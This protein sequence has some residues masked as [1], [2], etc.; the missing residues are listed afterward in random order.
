TSDA[1]GVSVAMNAAGDRMAIG[2]SGDDGA[3]NVVLNMGAVYLFSF[4]DSSFSS[5][6]LKGIIGKGYTGSGNIDVGLSGADAFGTSVA[7][8]A[9]GDSLAVGAVGDDGFGES[10]SA[11]GAVYLFTFADSNFSGGTH[12]GTIGKDYAGAGDFNLAPLE[13]DDSFGRSVSLNAAGNRLAVGT[14]TDNG[15][16]N[17]AAD[18]GAVYLLSFAD[19][20]FGG[21]SHAGTIGNGYIGAGDVSLSGVAA[22][23]LL[24]VSVALNAAGDRLAIGAAGDDGAGNAAD[25]SGAIHLISFTDT[26]FSGGT[27]SGT[28]G[29]GYVGGGDTNIS[30]LGAGDSFGYSVALNAAGNR[31]AAGAL[32]DAGSGDTTAG[33]GAVYLLSFSDG[34][35]SSGAQTAIVGKGYTGGKNIGI[36]EIEGSD[37]FGFSVALNGAGD[38]LAIGTYGDDGGNNASTGAG[39][40]Y[41]LGFSD[42][43]FSNGAVRGVLSRDSWH[44]GDIDI[45][46]LDSGDSFGVSVALN[47]AGDRMAVG[48]WA[49]SGFGNVTSGSGAVYLFSFDDANF[50]GG[51]L[52][53]IIGKGYAGGKNVDMPG[54]EMNDWFGSGVALNDSGDRL[55]VG[56]LG[57]DGGSTTNTGAVYLFTFSDDDFSDGTHVATVGKGYG[58]DVS[59]LA[60]NDQFGIS[61]ALNAAG[62]R[63]AVGAIGDKGANDDLTSA[64]AAYLI[65]FNDSNFTGGAVA[66]VIGADYAGTNDI[67]VTQ[68][69]A[70]DQFGVSVALNGAGNRLAVGAIGDGGSGDVAS[71]S[72]AVHLFSFTDDDFTGG[73]HTGTI[74]KGYTGGANVNVGALEAADQFG[75]G[76]SL[77]DA[78]NRLAVGAFGDGG[79]ANSAAGSG[80]VYLL[81]FTDGNFSG[82]SVT[83]TLG[84]NY[85]GSDKINVISLDNS[86]QF[87]VSVALNGAGDRLA[88]GATG[89]GGASNRTAVSGAVYLFRFE[90]TNFYGGSLVGMVGDGY[91][92]KRDIALNAA[93]DTGEQFGMAVALNGAGDRLAVG[94]Y[95]D[96]GAGNAAAASGAVYLFSFSDDQYS[97]GAL[98]AIVG[99]GYVGGKNVN[100]AQLDAADG[101]GFS[102]SL[103]DDGDRMAVGAWADAGLGNTTGGAGAVYLF[104]FSDDSFAGGAHVGTIGKGYTGTGNID[105]T[106]LAAADRFGTSVAL[107][108]AGDRLAAGAYLDD[109]VSGGA[110]D[111][112]GAVYLFR[113][114]DTDFGGGTHS[115]TIGKG[116]VGVGDVNVASLDTGDYF[117]VSAALNSVGD[118]LAVGATGDNGSGNSTTDAGAV[119]L[120]TFTNGD[121][122]GGALAG[123]IGKG[124]SGGKSRD[125]AALEASD[126]FGRSVA[127][128]GDGDY[129]VA[130]A[131]YDDG[132][133]NAVENAGALYLFTFSDTSFTG[134]VHKGTIGSGYAGTF[135]TALA[136]GT[137]DNLGV[138]AALSANGFRLAAGANGDDGASN[139]I[140]NSGAV[141]LFTTDLAAAGGLSYADDPDATVNISATSLAALLAAGTNLTL[142]ASNDITVSAAVT[143]NNALGDGGD[144]TLQAGRSVLLNASITTDNGDLTLIANDTLAN[145]VVDAHRDSGAAAITMGV[146][147]AIAAGTG[148]VTI[149]LRN[150]AGKTNT[151]AGDITLRAITAGA[152]TV[153][154]AATAGDILLNGNITTSGAQAYT[155]ERDI[156]LAASTTLTVTGAATLGMDAARQVSLTTGAKIENTYAGGLTP[157][158][159]IDI[160]ANRRATADAGT[161]SGIDLSGA[162]IRTAAGAAGSIALSARG[163]ASD[164]RGINMLGG[165]TIEAL[166]SGTI[167]LHGT[168]GTG[169]GGTTYGVF[170]HQ[171]SQVI[172]TNGDIEITGEAVGSGVAPGLY[173]FSGSQVR[174]TGTGDIALIGSAVAGGQGVWIASS[175]AGVHT[176]SGDISITATSGDGGQPDFTIGSGGTLGSANTNDITINAD[177]I[178][179]TGTVSG[180]GILTIQSRTDGRTIGL[181]S[182]A[183]DLAIDAAS[184]ANIQ[185]GFSEI[186]IGN[187]DAGAIT[188]GSGLSA[189][190]DNLRLQSAGALAIDGTLSTGSNRLTL[191]V[192]GGGTQ[193]AALTA[194]QLLLL[195][196]ASNYTFNH[197]GNTI[198]TLAASVGSGSISLTNG[199]GTSFSVGAIG[200]TEG[201]AAASIALVSSPTNG[202]ITFTRGV[203]TTGAQSY[204]SARDIKVSTGNVTLSASGE[205]PITLTAARQIVLSGTS[206]IENTNTTATGKFD[207]IILNANLADSAAEAN[208]HGIYG[209]NTKIMASG[210]GNIKLAGRG[211]ASSNNAQTARAGITFSGSTIQSE[212]GD[213]S[214]TGHGGGGTADRAMSGVVLQ[215]GSKFATV[216]GGNIDIKAYGSDAEGAS[217]AAAF[218][219][220]TGIV[221]A[222][223]SGSLTILGDGGDGNGLHGVRLNTVSRFQTAS[224]AISITGLGGNG[225]TAAH[226]VNIT[227]GTVSSGG[228]LTIDGTGGDETGHGIAIQGPV[229]ALG[230]ASISMTGHASGTSSNNS[231]ILVT[232]GGSITSA[233]GDITLTATADGTAGNFPALYVLGGATT[234]IQ[235]TAGGDIT[236]QGTRRNGIGE[237]VWIGSGGGRVQ[238][239][240]GDISITGVTENSTGSN[241][242]DGARIAASGQV[243]TSAGGDI[244]LTGTAAGSG[245]DVGL[246]GTGVLG[247]TATGD[248]TITGDTIGIAVTSSVA[249]SG[250]LTIQTR[251]AGRTIGIGTGAGGDLTLSA[252]AL[253]RLQNGF[254]E[255][256]IG[257]S[258]AGAISVGTGLSA[259]TDNLRLVGS[260]TLAVDGVL[261]TGGNRLT[262][263]IAG[264]TTQ[265]AGITATQLLLLND[266]GAYT[267]TNT[268]N[269][270]GTLAADTDVIELTHGGAGALAIG[271]V[272]A[273]SGIT[274]TSVSLTATQATSSLN[275]NQD[276]TTSGAQTY[277]ATLGNITVNSGADLLV[278]GKATLALTAGARILLSGGTL[279]NSYTADSDAFEAITLKA[280]EAGTGTGSGDAAIKLAGGAGISTAA[281]GGGNISLLGKGGAS[282]SHGIFVD[283]STIESLGAGTLTLTGTGGT[284]AGGTNIGIYLKGTDTDVVSNSGAMLISG[285]G[286]ASTGPQNYGVHIHDGATIASTGTGDD[287]AAIEIIGAAGGTGSGATNI[288]VYVADTSAAITSIDGDISVTGTG[289]A[290]STSNNNIGV[291]LINDA[292]IESTGTTANAAKITVIGNAGGT[293]ALSANNQGVSLQGAA[294]TITSA[295]GDIAITGTGSETAGSANNHGIHILEGAHIASTGTTPGAAKITL[296]GQGGGDAASATTN[297]NIGIY[298]SS[299]NTYI[300]S[301]VGDITMT[302]TGGAG[303]DG[304]DAHHYGIQLG[305]GTQVRSTGSDANAADIIVSGTGGSGTG[306]KRNG[307]YLNAVEALKSDAG[308]ISITARGGVSAGGTGNDGLYVSGVGTKVQ[309]GSGTIVVD[310]AKGGGTGKDLNNLTG[311][312]AVQSTT[313]RWI[314]YLTHPDNSTL[315]NLASGNLPIWGKTQLTLAPGSVGSGNRYVFANQPTLTVSTS[316]SDSKTYGTEYTFPT[317]TR[318]INYSVSGIV[319]ASSYQSVWTQETLSDLGISGAPEFSS[320]GAA[321]AANVAGSPYAINIA[322]G[323][324]ASSA[325]YAFGTPSSTGS[326]TVTPKTLT[327]TGVTAA[328]K[329]YDGDDDADLSGGAL[330]GVVGSD[331]VEFSAGAGAFASKNVGTWVVTATGYTLSGSAAANYEL[332]QPTVANATI[333]AKVLTLTGVAAAGKD[334][335]GNADAD[336]SGGSLVGIVGSEDVEFSAGSGTFASKNVGTWTITTTGYMLSGGDAGNYTLTQPAVANAT[337]SAKAL[338][339]TG[340]TAAGTDYD[341]DADADLSGGSLV[342]IVGSEDVE[343]AEGSG[344]FSSRNVGT[345]SVTASG[346]TLTGDDAGNYTLTQPTVATAT[347][348]AKA[349][350]LSSVT[351]AG[352]DYDGDNTADLS[353]GALVGI[354][355]SED[356]SFSA[357]SGTFASKNVGTWTITTT[358]YTLTG[359]DAGNYTLTQP[360]VANAT[361]SAK[362]L[363][364]TGVGAAGKDYDGNDA[365]ALSG[366]TLI[367][368]VG[369]E[370]VTF[371]AGSGN[372]SSKN[373]GTWSITTSGY[374]LS[375]DDAGNYTLTQPTVASAAI[376]AK[377]LTLGGIT[378]ADKDYDG[379]TDAD[380]SGGTLFGVVGSDDVSFVSGSGV[381]GSRNA[382][383]W[384]VTAT[385]YALSGDDA[386]NYTLTQ[387][388]VANATISPRT[389]NA[390]VT[391][392]GK[393]YDGT[394][395]AALTFSTG[396]IVTGDSVTFAY[397]AQFTD[398]AAGMGK[399]V[400]LTGSVT[401]T[402]T[403]AANYTL[404]LDPSDVS[405]LAA[406]IMARTLAVSGVGALDKIYDGGTSVGLSFATAD[407]LSGDT[408]TFDYTANFA[409]KKAGVGK[410]VT[411][412]GVSL[413]GADGGNY[414]LVLDGALLAGLTA[415]I[416]RKALTLDTAAAVDKTYDGNRN[417]TL[418]FTTGD[419]VSG[420]DIGFLY[421]ALAADGNA[422]TGKAVTVTGDTVSISGTD[423]D[424]YDLGFDPALLSG[425]AIDIAARTLNIT[426]VAALDKVYDG[427]RTAA[428][429]ITATG[430]VGGDDAAFGYDARFADKNVGAGKPVTVVDSIRLSGA[431]AGNYVI[432]LDPA[433]LGSLSADITAK[434]LSITDVLALAKTYNGSRDADLAFV[435]DD[436]VGGDSVGF[437]YEALF[438]DKNAGADKAIDV[439]GSAVVLTGADAGNYAL[440]LDAALLLGLSADIARKTLTVT[441]VAAVGKTYDGTRNVPLD[442]TTADILAGDN[443]VFDYEALAADRNAGTGK[444][445]TVGGV[446]LSGED[447]G[448]YDLALDDGLLGGLTTDV[449]AKALTVVV[450]DQSRARFQ[451]NPAFTYHLVGLAE[452]D[453]ASVVSDVTLLTAATD[454]SLVGRYAIEASGGSAPNYV[455]A[456]APGTLTVTGHLIPPYDQDRIQHVPGNLSGSD[457]FGG[458]VSIAPSPTLHMLSG[459]ADMVGEAAAPDGRGPFCSDPGNRTRGQRLLPYLQ[460]NMSGRTLYCLGS[461]SRFA[462]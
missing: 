458:L 249:G 211:I 165:S 346:Y 216:G 446:S 80:A 13:T 29:K 450:D 212:H 352:K 414:V 251:T 405:A 427:T 312:T 59:G 369:G 432:V 421:E 46:A 108:A 126:Q 61:V 448:N 78:G 248:I 74:G 134:G 92:R 403:D 328:G 206:R 182:G 210:Y 24:G 84:K 379:D 345:W 411:A 53:G 194:G 368:I 180:N 2:A 372:F 45:P 367:G 276:V 160:T 3:G 401:L 398:K 26:N 359:D 263:D 70:S 83:T 441:D 331:D 143:V 51:T 214:V 44:T 111:D 433:L 316:F 147:T 67:D 20:A 415:D 376:T 311:S 179:F 142:Q 93:P 237:G 230:S 396:D 245:N 71:A 104:S 459:Y 255:I 41:L 281:G 360:A 221:E 31:L 240:S 49:D 353:G 72:G 330:D 54:L 242:Y 420:D 326:L 347:I 137:G 21:V 181:G 426:A 266:T 123:T 14:W 457:G 127:L 344:L 275:F 385:G 66:G 176:M 205:V 219:L 243:S 383:T 98:E 136:L 88:V 351:A 65:R 343:F 416:D 63:L 238:T 64:G 283:G 287:A 217:S 341:G 97:D 428:L 224:G 5:G 145:G 178:G 381:F 380:L 89:D 452:G 102:V 8:N 68:L 327:I 154:S 162:I 449:A 402:G 208:L 10:T 306:N 149:D 431:D 187:A 298:L 386:G 422:G 17:G 300:E 409:D 257:N 121:F 393:I 239:T 55:A 437:G 323:T 451:P 391:A 184:L 293:G 42:G 308:N 107:N 166:G 90:D 304:V 113:F 116:Y 387:P 241:S 364:L 153:T 355:G 33:A 195:G 232:T 60:M 173:V 438:A 406:D 172:G 270:I 339:L 325:G 109:G 259:F 404:A 124:Y 246:F 23:D 439:T 309:S 395:D 174:T 370:D 47:G 115:G 429:T 264:A 342:G 336:L 103:N 220:N 273:V 322:N 382:G 365:A 77:N 285:T 177:T 318:G 252:S 99:K 399:A 16:A 120:F 200:S 130:G 363:T 286:G 417:V 52:S 256:V 207:A 392:D 114:T 79:N 378:A 434:T 377:A 163:G 261:N 357:G 358:G 348:S 25:A 132:A 424:N 69:G 158:A 301:I 19:T 122:G 11:A 144:L 40:V 362:V 375:G 265:S 425:L 394:R 131:N 50:S 225:S 39:A 185:N 278:T 9:A 456:Y 254:S 12:V 218:D 38:R 272:G 313:G 453:D 151:A 260:Q 28:V 22:G 34:N 250:V 105:L 119:H 374:T 291:R 110:N 150:G 419:L 319:S 6:T 430:L 75:R 361:I 455:L 324:L 253:G 85:S 303:S 204:N 315:N 48:A 152:L 247:V 279:A 410:G 267:L 62:D 310:A 4:A 201:I 388:T 58:V 125:L 32:G 317:P 314:I 141:Y 167:T 159:A 213:L 57:D 305:L 440:S 112:Y 412:S 443:V 356:V 197:A 235:S 296:S 295:F 156:K 408:V 95:A 338:T 349:L 389:L 292:R 202:D 30:A 148:A 445:V 413:S 460:L 366:G 423:A 333:S 418:D 332:T 155:S 170:L 400:S 133:G 135:D 236:L 168:S 447:A 101:F 192:A 128:N 435:T 161:L 280:N 227:G 397:D 234:A 157:F 171:S 189:F 56:A 407:I 299:P 73:S 82:G 76:I 444:V 118:R 462:Q 371:A 461:P 297:T 164:G 18:S 190:V 96:N 289:A 1:F 271:A 117:G 335:D 87:G 269:D 139:S 7:L 193:S 384:S 226:G 321:A 233:T 203:T 228:E 258:T 288:G 175:S 442:F 94:A 294:A 350:T 169:S 106:P 274:A 81:S 334:Y 129:L 35:F 290:A 340:V 37:A 454:A 183:G 43:N 307:V 140:S 86:D 337:I 329:D 390:G 100:V 229:S 244:L 282:I 436:I 91:V 231:G 277:S 320:S 262:L 186:I 373:V 188:V 36:P 138:S 199:S 215:W 15:F 222:T 27:L 209:D 268:G 354:V 284:A 146:G 196:T 191:D 223:G 302:G 198:G